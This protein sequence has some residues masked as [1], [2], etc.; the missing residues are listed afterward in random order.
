[1]HGLIKSVVIELKG[2]SKSKWLA[3]YIAMRSAIYDEWVRAYK[4]IQKYWDEICEKYAAIKES[5][6]WVRRNAIERL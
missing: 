2:K 1:M 3:Y 5:F 4:E 6:M